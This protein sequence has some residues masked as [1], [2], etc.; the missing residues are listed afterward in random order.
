MNMMTGYILPLVISLCTLITEFSAPEC[1][2]YRPRFNEEYCFFQ[3]VEAKTLW[4]F[5]PIGIFLF[6]NALMFGMAILIICKSTNQAEKMNMRSGKRSPKMEKFVMYLKLFLG[7]GF[8][9]T[10]EI[11]SGLTHKS[12]GAS[13]WW[14]TDVLN[15]SQGFY[16]F[17]VFICKR[18]V[19]NVICGEDKRGVDRDNTFA[20]TIRSSVRKRLIPSRSRGSQ[21]KTEVFTLEDRPDRKT[22]TTSSI[23]ELEER[24]PIVKTNPAGTSNA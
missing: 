17:F 3:E 11:I 19:F 24:T 16:I 22:S 9:W 21:R 14:F 8:I 5:V 18:K 7:M 12:T 1:S 23:S 20:S 15:M 13:A 10:F 2:P 6:I 4:F